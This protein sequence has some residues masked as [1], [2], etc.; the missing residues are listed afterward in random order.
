MG[1]L[2]QAVVSALRSVVAPAATA[3]WQRAPVSAAAGMAIGDLGVDQAY[4]ADLTARVA[5]ASRT[6][7]GWR[8]LLGRLNSRRSVFSA[9][10]GRPN[11]G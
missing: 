10:I 6:R 1:E 2:Y 3:A 11:Q 9:P 5:A 4:V 8:R 7:F